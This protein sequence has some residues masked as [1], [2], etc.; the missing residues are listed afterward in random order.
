[1][2][3]FKRHRPRRRLSDSGPGGLRCPWR[4]CARF[5]GNNNPRRIPFR[6]R[7]RMD[8]LVP[9]SSGHAGIR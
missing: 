1:M 5:L 2:A 6:D 8:P 9:P 3:H 7:R 4:C